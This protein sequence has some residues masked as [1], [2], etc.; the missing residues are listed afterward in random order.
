MHSEQFY[1]NAFFISYLILV[2]W[3]MA[4]VV[5]KK[6]MYKT[7]LK[8]FNIS[9]IDFIRINYFLMGFYKLLVISL[10]L[11]PFLSLKLS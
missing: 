8:L 1:L 5:F 4:I 2:I 11:V 7:H 6:Q 10:F 9:E 3:F